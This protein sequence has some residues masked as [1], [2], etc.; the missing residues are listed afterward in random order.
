MKKSEIDFLRSEVERL[1]KEFAKLKMQRQQAKLDAGLPINES[2]KGEF[3]K[4]KQDWEIDEIAKMQQLAEDHPE[5]R[6]RTLPADFGEM[7]QS[8]Q[9]TEGK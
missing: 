2:E 4:A 8:S 5:M 1:T 3:N 7:K 9:K 6:P